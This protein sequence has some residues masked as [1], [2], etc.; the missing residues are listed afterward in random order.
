MRQLKITSS[1]TNRNDGCLEKYLNEISRENILTADEEALLAQRIKQG[2]KPAMDKLVKCN[3]RFVVSVAK[4]YQGQGMSLS[5]LINEGNLG[6][7]KAA[8]KFDETKGFKFISYA[9]W[10][11][12][13]S[14]MMALVEKVR[15]VRIPFNQVNT[16]G[17][18]K[19]VQHEYEQQFN[20]EPNLYELSA[21]LQLDFNHLK[22]VMRSSS[23]PVS[24]DQP[25]NSD[26]SDTSF[27][28]LMEDKNVD[29]TDEVVNRESVHY[30]VNRTLKNLKPRE[31]QILKMFYGIG[32]IE[33]LSIEQIAD[34][35]ELTRERVRQ[36]K[37]KAIRKLKASSS[38]K[39]LRLH[40]A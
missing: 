35:L 23:F 37:E 1:I 39:V 28:D 3:L 16:L 15:T 4:Q 38:T 9:V 18:I 36:V 27:G 29:P 31:A 26:E 33:Q 11:I 6:L 12:R 30:D 13:Q 14:I 34:K 32:F 19:R 40:L 24:L 21:E 10:W 5:D 2:D 25:I 22:D 7:I 8:H 17:R 20:R